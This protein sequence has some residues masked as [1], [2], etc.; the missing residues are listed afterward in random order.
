M[1]QKNKITILMAF[2]ASISLLFYFIFRM[3]VYYSIRLG[4]F[5]SLFGLIL[6]LAEGHSILQSLGFLIRIINLKK[7]DE[8]WYRHAKLNKNNLP[9][10]T[11]LVPAR[12]EPLKVLE[13]TFICLA[14]LN[15][16]NKII[17]FLDGSDSEL[18]AENEKLAKK[19]GI[20]HFV[21]EQPSKS[22]AEIINK[23]LPQITTEYLSVFDA[24]QNPMPS[25]LMEV[26]SLIE[27]SKKIAFVQTPQ[28]YTN[29][30]I[31]PVARGSSLQQSIFFENIC[32]GKGVNNSMFCCGTNFVM[33]TDVLKKVGG[34]DEKSVTEDFATSVQIHALG[35]KSIYYKHVRVFGM[36]PETLPAY[37]KQQ[38]RWAGGTVGVIRK[39]MPLIV[40]GKI[41]LSL[42]QSWEYFLSA[43]YYF[44]GWSFFVLIMSPAL[45][46]LFRFPSYF[47]NPYFYLATFITY[48]LLTLTTF[49]ATMKRRNYKDRDVFIGTMMSSLSFPILMQSTL[50]GLFNKKMTFQITNKGRG[51]TMPL[52]N[53]WP[54]ILIILIN[55]AAIINGGLRYSENHYAIGINMFWCLYHIIFISGIF[56]LNKMPK[57]KNKKVLNYT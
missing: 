42:G 40:R 14:S 50:S 55:I 48:Y 18:L 27:Y 28:L 46:L 21:P 35:Y 53:M 8:N 51:E 15:Y 29:I 43:T 13:T 24:D 9:G 16:N 7:T 17:Y 32:E 23:I 54:W 49:Y 30:D 36:A 34:F 6:L 57:I 44:T 20:I 19:Y 2:L 41:K 11:I 56:K 39:L 1:N 25:F 5:S 38:F 4:F 37:F 45:Y 10:V 52:I 33:R 22:K 47:A 12:N 3:Y 26:V 31:S